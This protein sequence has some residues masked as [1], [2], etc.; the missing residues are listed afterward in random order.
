MSSQLLLSRCWSARLGVLWFHTPAVLPP[1]LPAVGGA[2]CSFSSSS[3][4]GSSS[5]R[6]NAPPPVLAIR[7]EESSV[8]ERRAPL[9]PGH[10]QN[11]VRD[12]VRVSTCSA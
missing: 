3:S 10:V 2:P 7:R 4:S 8:W 6:G 1:G 12:G 11:L 9:N 5:S